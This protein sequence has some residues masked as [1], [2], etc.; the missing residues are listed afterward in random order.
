MHSDG[1]DQTVANRPKAALRKRTDNQVIP[2]PDASFER[3]G[4]G[5]HFL[6][7]AQP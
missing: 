1:R 5:F 4:G 7:L 3:I 6:T 2:I